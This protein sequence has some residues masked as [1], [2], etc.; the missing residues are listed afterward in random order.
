MKAVQLNIPLG[1]S[2]K[3]E[4]HE[5]CVEQARSAFL[6]KKQDNVTEARRDECR[7]IYTSHFVECP[8][9]NNRVYAYARK[10]NKAF[11]TELSLDERVD[12]ETVFSWT[13]SQI[14]FFD[15]E[16]GAL[17]LN[18]V[19][20]T[21]MTLTCPKCKNTMYRTDK[22]RSVQIRRKRH[23]V[24][25]RAE[26]VDIMEYLLQPCALPDEYIYSGE[27]LF[28]VA[29]FNFRNG[30]TYLSLERENGETV[31]TRDVTC[32]KYAWSSG[33]VY[34]AVT[35]SKYVR[36]IIRKMF[37][38]EWGS[39]IPFCPSELGVN[40][41]RQ[42]VM[43]TGYG[44]EFYSAIPFKEGTICIEESFKRQA[45]GLRKAS[46]TV[47]L[48]ANSSLPNMKCVK[49]LFL[50]N[51]G[52]FF[53]LE[54][55]EKLWKLLSDPNHFT[56]L[57]RINEIYQI[58]S[59]LHTRPLIFVFLKDFLKL[60]PKKKLLKKMRKNWH[61]T[62]S[63]AVN[64][65]TMSPSMQKHE[66]ESWKKQE[67]CTHIGGLPYFAI[68]VSRPREHIRNCVIDGFEFFWLKTSTDYREA[69]QALNNCL[70]EWSVGDFPVVCVRC[71]GRIVAAIE[72]RNNFIQQAYSSDNEDLE[73]E[74]GLLQAY[75]CWRDKN[76][77]TERIIYD[78][79]D[80]CGELP[81]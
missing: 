78:D 16:R 23:K 25:L 5:T 42:L 28:E 1:Y 24:Y 50:E 36:R 73:K 32:D 20:D 69:S 43:F 21:E 62:C 56:A 34:N 40:E 54:E 37:C 59:D 57:F 80:E 30:H 44:K 60:E 75:Y 64:Y 46:N 10:F 12:R 4:E 63:Y 47:S 29:C 77:L 15:S 9:C 2:I 11:G 81:F 49:K 38:E 8:F 55:C 52:L 18:R 3:S 26:L 27:V 68:P 79:D 71:N 45:L 74:P 61:W 35:K 22:T 48:Y 70:R 39:E 31:A 41:L 51:S 66:R 14:G 13:T 76:A 65:A 53:Y 33:A 67:Y 7:V 58:L 19:V 72:I 17:V 6:T